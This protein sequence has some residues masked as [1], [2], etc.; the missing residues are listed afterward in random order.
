MDTIICYTKGRKSTKE[1]AKN[2][3]IN[4]EYTTAGD[5]FPTTSGSGGGNAGDPTLDGF[6]DP[7]TPCS[8]VLGP[9]LTALVKEAIKWVRIAG[10][11]IAIVNGM[12]KL[13][14]AIM[15]KDAE[16]LNKAFRT[17][18]IMAIVLVF[19]VLFDWLL[20]LI[21]SIFKWDVSCVI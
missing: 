18:I 8:D 4:G 20:G 15:S 6:G 11:I 17:C 19:C 12:L 13:I 7:K 5:P 9:T 16:A 1:E 10:A 14:P 21:G 3:G 2:N